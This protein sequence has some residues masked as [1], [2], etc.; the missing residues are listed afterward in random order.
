MGGRSSRMG[1]DKALLP[2][3]GGALAQSVARAVSAT[4]GSV[5]LVGDPERY[6][7]LGYAVIADIYPG[8]GPLGGI[9]T[10]LGNT[11]RRLEPHHRLRYAATGRGTAA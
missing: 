11:Q 3:R 4:A 5:T 9:L 2:F 6:G 10:A 7:G 1:R 8:E